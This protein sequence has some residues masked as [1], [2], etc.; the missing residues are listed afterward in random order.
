[1]S[2]REKQISYINMCVWNLK[3]GV[4]EPIRR[5]GIESR[6]REPTWGNG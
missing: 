3:N 1:M 2:K 4:D 5:A 6:G